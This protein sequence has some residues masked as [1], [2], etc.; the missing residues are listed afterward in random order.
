MGNNRFYENRMAIREVCDRLNLTAENGARAWA[1][2]TE[3]KDYHAELIEWDKLCA[4][5]AHD[6]KKTL[7]DLFA[8]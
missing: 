6:S 2:E 5:Y 3:Q 1:A 7:A 8:V 4:E